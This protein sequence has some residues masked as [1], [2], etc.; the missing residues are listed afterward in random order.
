MINCSKK[1]DGHHTISNEIIMKTVFYY[2][3]L[4]TNCSLLGKAAAAADKDTDAPKTICR[5]RGKTKFSGRDFCTVKKERQSP[6]CGRNL[7]SAQM[8]GRN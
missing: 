4:K 1:S 7:A 6:K 3:V 8:L 5:K 2:R